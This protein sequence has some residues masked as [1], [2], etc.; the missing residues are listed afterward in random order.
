MALPA[1]PL[2]PRPPANLRKVKTISI[3]GRSSK[4]NRGLL[5]SVPAPGV[6]FT[7]WFA[8]LPAILKANDL[9]AVVKALA[10][11]VRRE[12]AV[13]WMMGAHP[14]KCGLTPLLAEMI[15]RRW[16][17]TLCLNGAGAI[18]DYEIAC[19]GETSEDV[20]AGLADG[21][22]GMV[23]ETATGIFSALQKYEGA[24]RGFGTALGEAVT[25]TRGANKGLSLLATAFDHNVPATVHV[26]LGTDIIHQ[27]PQADGALMGA[28]SMADFRLLAGQLPDLGDGGV[29]VNLGSAVL[30]PEVF[31]KALTV[32]RN[33]GHPVRDFTAVNFDMIQHYRSNMNV[34]GRPTRTGGKGYSITGHHEILV[35]I[36]FA[37]LQEELAMPG[38]ARG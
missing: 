11:A 28:A 1:M 15:R 6:S 20:E 5:A 7:D 12:R 29:V 36:L 3:K 9:H 38:G 10:E 31:L 8:T 26:A 21:T 33:L 17:T 19:F 18:H 25:R 14:V 35:P 13:V 27:H 37:A 34:V 16:I 23:K 24:T 2:Q 30:L 32:A 4:V 22:F